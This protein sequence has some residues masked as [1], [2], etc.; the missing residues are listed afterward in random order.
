M[1]T[2]IGFVCRS[3]DGS[4][5]QRLECRSGLLLYTH[6]ASL[7]CLA[8]CGPSVTAGTNLYGS[9]SS[10]NYILTSTYLLTYLA[11]HSVIAGV[12]L[13]HK[14]LMFLPITFVFICLFFLGLC[15]KVA[16][17]VV[18]LGYSVIG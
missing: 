1:R 13:S 14:R 11:V 15:R 18:H 9:C 4:Y 16:G 7:L 3:C 10:R 6:R 2:M 17:T 5:T 12:L 8:S